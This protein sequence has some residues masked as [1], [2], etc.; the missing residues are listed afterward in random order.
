MRNLKDLQNLAKSGT[1]SKEL[2]EDKEFLDRFK[3]I[4]EEESN[5]KA[6]D[7]EIPII[8]NNIEKALQNDMPINEEELQIVSGGKAILGSNVKSKVIKGSFATL[9]AIVGAILGGKGGTFVGALKPEPKLEK[10]AEEISEEER[11]K[12]E[13]EL[14]DKHYGSI[15]EIRGFGR[16]AGMLGGAYGGYKLGELICKK[17]NIDNTI[18]NKNRP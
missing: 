16:G 11:K 7:K 15:M 4:L 6:T 18:T 1:F 13:Q 8:I 5:I 9:G 2:L 12:Q 3:K 14:I 17:F 10:K